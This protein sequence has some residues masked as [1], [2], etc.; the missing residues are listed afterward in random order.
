MKRKLSFLQFLPSLT[1]VILL[2]TA[3]QSCKQENEKVTTLTSEKPEYFNLRPT[4]EKNMAT[5]TL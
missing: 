2:S 1:I 5:H 4:L 3:A